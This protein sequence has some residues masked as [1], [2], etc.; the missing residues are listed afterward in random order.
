MD[1]G[2]VLRENCECERWCVLVN[3]RDRHLESTE[4]IT[5]IY[6]P[7]FAGTALPTLCMLWIS[8]ELAMDARTMKVSVVREWFWL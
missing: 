1:T 6:L 2:D 5:T 3:G 7:C 4:D 8:D